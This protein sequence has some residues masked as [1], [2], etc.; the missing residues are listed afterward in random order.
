M[1][2]MNHIIYQQSRPDLLLPIEVKERAFRDDRSVVQRVCAAVCG[3]FPALS[4]LEKAEINGQIGIS[5][6]LSPHA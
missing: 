1:S 6:T 5:V 2:Q 4:V 3:A